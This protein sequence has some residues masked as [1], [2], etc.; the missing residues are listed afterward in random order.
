MGDAGTRK[1]SGEVCCCCDRSRLLL[2]PPLLLLLLLAMSAPE[3]VQTSSQRD[4]CT[5]LPR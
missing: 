2:L 4:A 3:D 1:E 5:Q